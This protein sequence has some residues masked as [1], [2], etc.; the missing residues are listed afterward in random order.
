L[1][2]CDMLILTGG[3]GPTQDDLTREAVADFLSV[4]LLFNPEAA[5]WLAE[6][7]GLTRD[8]IPEGQ[9]PQVKVP[10]GATPL[11]NPAGTACGFR[12]ET[13][14][15]RVFAF[16]GVPAEFHAM[17]DLH[18][19]PE[20]QRRDAILLRRKLVTFGLPESRQRE[21]LKDFTPPVPFRF[22]SLPAESGVVIAIEALVPQAQ[23]ASHSVRLEAAWK[24]LIS[25]LPEDCIV[26]R[27]GLSLPEA[28]FLLLRSRKSTVAV[29]ESCT[30]G[31]LGFLLTETPGS[32]EVFR[33][34]VLAYANEAKTQWLGVSTK[35]LAEHGAVSEP[36]ALAMARGCREAANTDYAV[37]IT[38]IAGPDGGTPEKPVGLVYIG[39]ASSRGAK[40]YRFQFR[41][42]DRN[43]LRWRSAYTALNQLRLFIINDL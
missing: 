16:P 1:P 6:R 23:A 7:L 31:A 11:R 5:A 29:A 9:L 22:S 38:G 35:L 18:C 25:R 14:G 2:R 33:Q 3:L 19:R 27:G 40:V 10:R 17:F 39:V 28:V 26:D 15:T 4:P 32:S 21:L 37:A 24:E 43:S 36:V 34:G 41:A 20:L 12:F 13:S 42:G 8:D 30:A